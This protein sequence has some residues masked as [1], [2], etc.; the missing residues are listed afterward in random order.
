MKRILIFLGAALL[1]LAP[2]A[3]VYVPVALAHAEP[4]ECTPAIDGTV[5]TIPDKVVCTMTQALDAKQSKLQVFDAAGVQVDKGDSAVDLNNPDR[6]V[7][8]VSL[9]TTKMQDGVYTVKWET[10][11]TDDN[12]DAN[13]EFKFTVKSAASAQPTGVATST[14]EPT[15]A[16][17]TAVEPTVAPTVAPTPEPTPSAPATTLPATGAAMS[18]VGFALLAFLGLLLLGF[19]LMTRARR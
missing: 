18:N 19:G 8:S 3:L 2:M 11:S 6:N 4:K 1:M 17:T 7:I 13:G 9:D 10:Y 16:P 5:T 14:A 12:E 15:A